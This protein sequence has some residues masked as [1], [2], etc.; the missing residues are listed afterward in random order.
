M[1]IINTLG[2]VFIIIFLGALLTRVRFLDAHARRII[3]ACCYWIG[4]P[5]LLALKIGTATDS[6]GAAGTTIMI[7]LYGT[8]LLMAASA[9]IG[10]RMKLNP[11][12]LATF[13]HVSFRGNLAYLGLPIIYFAFSGSEYADRAESV[14]A[15]TLGILVV[16][17]NVAAVLI[18][19]LSTHRVTIS[20]MKPVFIK[21]I[22]NPLLLSCGAGLAWNHWAHLNGVEIPVVAFRTLSMLGQF[23][24]PMALLCVGSALVTTPVRDIAAGA[25]VSAV[26]KTGAGP[27]AAILFSRILGAGVM[28]TGIACILLGAPTAIASYVLTEQLDGKP[29]LA[30]ATIVMSTLICSVTFSIIIACIH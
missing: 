27:L 26:I 15:I 22:T 10:W 23:A 28:E 25:I 3:N 4:L 9:L 19:L 29:S 8:F 1:H 30:A 16:V 20:A 12:E 13:V 7:M 11:R 2:P 18:H 17:Y 14:A 6:G 5:C 21:L 24:L